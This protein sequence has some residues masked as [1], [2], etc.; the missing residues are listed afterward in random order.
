[1]VNVR[2]VQLLTIPYRIVYAS[3]NWVD[4]LFTAT[5]LSGTYL[6]TFSHVF[7]PRIIKQCSKAC[8]SHPSPRPFMSSVS[9]CALQ[10]MSTRSHR[11]NSVPQIPVTLLTS[12]PWQTR[13]HSGLKWCYVLDNDM[14]YNGNMA[15]PQCPVLLTTPMPLF[16]PERRAL[17]DI[18]KNKG[19]EWKRYRFQGFYHPVN[20]SV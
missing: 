17:V 20:S 4:T 10:H 14:L 19:V 6:S 1:M 9:H 18:L 13:H 11:A 3:R 5:N 12:L 8:T 2:A 16:N 7:Q 15:S